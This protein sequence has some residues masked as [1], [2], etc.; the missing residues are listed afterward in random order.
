M[1]GTLKDC[2]YW[3]PFF[4]CNNVIVLRVFYENVNC[5]FKM[6]IFCIF[7]KKINNKS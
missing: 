6:N 5:V 7:I 3:N 4:F 2:A 1:H